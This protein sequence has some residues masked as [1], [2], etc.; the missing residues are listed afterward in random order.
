[1]TELKLWLL[2]QDIE[3]GYDTYDSCVVV[4]ADE[5][6]ARHITP[7]VSWERSRFHSWAHEPSQV[8]AKLIGTALDDQEAGTII[9][10]SFNAG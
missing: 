9:L 10:S 6:Q 2:T 4:A 8:S 7:D 3:T 5:E 1:M